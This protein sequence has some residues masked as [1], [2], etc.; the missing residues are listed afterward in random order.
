MLPAALKAR[1]SFKSGAKEPL[2]TSDESKDAPGADMAIVAPYRQLTMA[3][4]ASFKHDLRWTKGDNSM[5]PALASM[6]SYYTFGKLS[7]SSD[8]AQ[9]GNAPP[10]VCIDPL[11]GIGSTMLEMHLQGLKHAPTRPIIAMAGD[12]RLS[13]ARAMAANFDVSHYLDQCEDIFIGR[14]RDLFLSRPITA[15]AFQWDATKL[16]FK[17]SSVDAIIS[18]LP[19]GRRCGNA[20]INDQ[21]YTKLLVEFHRVLVPYHSNSESLQ[22]GRCVLLTIER[23]L[24]VTAL[25]TAS[26]LGAKFRIVM[27]PFV[28]DMGGLVPYVFVLEKM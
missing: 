23:R 16:P 17:D 8:T 7:C 11:G 3:R 13:E 14:N 19:F 18:D 22:P 28:V 15:T 2:V 25:V 21:L 27:A 10:F 4:P 1:S 20:T 24:M 26:L 6:L 5:N 12:L 9:A